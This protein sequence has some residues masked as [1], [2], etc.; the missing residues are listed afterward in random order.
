MAFCT[1]R[2]VHNN[3]QWT[4]V[5]WVSAGQREWTEFDC[6]LSGHAPLTST[7]GI[8]FPFWA[9][10]SVTCV[11][12]TCV[13]AYGSAGSATSKLADKLRKLKTSQKPVGNL[14]LNKHSRRRHSNSISSPRCRIAFGSDHIQ[15]KCTSRLSMGSCCSIVLLFDSHAAWCLKWLILLQSF[16]C[17]FQKNQAFYHLRHRFLSKKASLKVQESCL[18]NFMEMI[19]SCY[20]HEA[21]FP[22]W[23]TAD[24]QW[25]NWYKQKIAKTCWCQSLREQHAGSVVS[26]VGPSLFRFTA[27]NSD[28]RIPNDLLALFGIK[29]ATKNPMH[30]HRLVF[31]Q[32]MCRKSNSSK[33]TGIRITRVTRS[34]AP[35]ELSHR[36]VHSQWVASQVWGFHGFQ[37]LKKVNCF[38]LL[39]VSLC[40]IPW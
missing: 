24:F 29:C 14:C 12:V 39:L 4:E 31:I 40:G 35:I 19:L 3:P 5:E 21:V 7:T 13:V 11:T 8:L 34:I 30:L 22:A 2:F 25:Y 20:Q 6:C 28:I 10:Q 38:Q 36:R 1:Q 37:Y 32:Q 27:W 26:Q 18:S 17:Q 15:A 16:C 9:L 23:K 33:C